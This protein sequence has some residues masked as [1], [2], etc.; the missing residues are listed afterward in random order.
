M[1]LSRE[2]LVMRVSR[3]GAVSPTARLAGD[4]SPSPSRDSHMASRLLPHGFTL[5][6]I[7]VQRVIN[8]SKDHQLVTLA[9]VMP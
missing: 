1:R 9:D 6:P 8:P 2:H 4:P 3:Q 7:W 5:T